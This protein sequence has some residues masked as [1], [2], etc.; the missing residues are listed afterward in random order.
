MRPEPVR[1]PIQIRPAHHE[2]IP[3]YIARIAAVHN[4]KYRTLWNHLSAPAPGHPTRRLIVIE[5]L[6]AAT[7]RPATALQ[8]ALLEL[9][10]PA[11]D[12]R[13]YRHHAQPVCRR[14]TA[15]HPGGTVQQLRQHH[16]YLCPHGYW[17]GPATLAEDLTPLHLT[18]TIPDLRLT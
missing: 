14:C 15:S 13:R 10:D 5:R 12:W 6:A 4:I 8:Q 17:H 18:P 9:A 3:S 7:G 11:P 1:L 2:T 16:E